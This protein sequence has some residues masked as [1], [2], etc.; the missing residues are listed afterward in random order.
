M[1]GSPNSE[2]VQLEISPDVLARLFES[3]QLCAGEFRC[4]NQDSKQTVWSLCLNTCG[5][6]LG[7]DQPLGESRNNI[8]VLQA[9]EYNLQQ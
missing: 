8:Q 5:K 1:M 6:C 4:L 7:E 2:K 9:G 3:G